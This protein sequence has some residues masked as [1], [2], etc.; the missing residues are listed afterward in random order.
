M[1]LDIIEILV[2]MKQ[3]GTLQYMNVFL[4]KNYNKRSQDRPYNL[5]SFEHILTPTL[6]LLYHDLIITSSE[7]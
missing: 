5:M 6:I 7:S 2:N 3:K 4:K 1:H